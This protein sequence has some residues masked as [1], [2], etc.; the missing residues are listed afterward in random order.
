MFEF[1]R[2]HKRLMQIFLMLLIVPSFVLVGVPGM[3]GGSSADEVANVGGIKITQQQWDEEQRKQMDYYRQMAGDRF[4]QKLFE[5]PEAKQAALDK[6]ITDRVI[7]LELARNNMRTTDKAVTQQILNDPALKRPDGSFDTA[8][9]NIRVANMGMSKAQFEEYVRQEMTKAQINNALQASTIVPRTVSKRLSDF[10]SEEREVQ[11][12]LFPV[13][14]YS[15][16]VS[17]TPA[18]IKAYYDKNAAKFAVPEQVQIEYVVF[19]ADS[20]IS[21]VTV[22]DAE[23]AAAYDKDIKRFTVPAERKASHILIAAPKGTSAEQ[24]A[25]AKAKAE[26]LLAKVRAAPGEFAALAKA[27]SDDTAS[28][29]LGGDLGV[30]DEKTIEPAIYKASSTLKQGEVSG[31]VESEFGYHI[32]MLTSDK[33]QS[34]KPLDTVKDTLVAELKQAKAGKLYKDTIETLTDTLYSQSDSLKPVA[35][36]LKLTIATAEGVTRSPSLAAGTAPYN[37]PKFLEALFASDSLKKKNNTEPVEVAPSTL[38]AGRIVK[39]TPASVRPLAEVEAEITKSVT[40][41]QSIALARKAGE[42]KMAAAKASGD[43]SGFGPAQ[44]VSRLTPPTINPGAVADVLKADASKLPAYVGVE[45]PGQS[46]A[47]YRIGK[48][49]QPATPNLAQRTAEQEQIS[50]VQAQHEYYA[51]LEALKVKAKTKQTIKPAVAPK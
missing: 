48:V 50:N 23:I 35:D 40:E 39:H 25:A 7:M 49:G 30:I 19:N 4:D 51:Y 12:L 36:K 22:S 5:T 1:I 26:A 46:Y 32:V 2:N 13:A 9:Y 21:Q 14:E 27:N 43:A 29:E 31:V 16:Q 42:A 45:I 38:V 11:E 3:M 18:M 37:H 24:K 34:V 15:S 10:T 33:P 47:L 41:E 20:V 28:N 17:V 8:M 44:V 6:L